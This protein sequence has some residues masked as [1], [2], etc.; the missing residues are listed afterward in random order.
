[1]HCDPATIPATENSH[2]PWSDSSLISGKVQSHFLMIYVHIYLLLTALKT[3]LC[4]EEE[5]DPAAGSRPECQ[6]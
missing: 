6:A 3:C 2:Q 1:M 5:V 4:D